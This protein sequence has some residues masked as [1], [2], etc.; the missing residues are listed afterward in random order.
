MHEH[1][2]HILIVDDEEIVR[3]VCARSLEGRGYGIDT[4]ENGSQ[5][6]KRLGRK[7]YEI[8]FTDL[9]MPIVNG[10]ELL[11][12]IKR[13]HPYTEVIV[14]TGFATV[15]GAI[16][17]MK[18]GAYD[19]ILKPIKPDQ[20]RLTVEKCLSRLRLSKENEALRLANQKLLELKEIKDKFIAITSHELRTPVSHIKGYLD[21]VL[22][23]ELNRQLSDKE[24]KQCREVILSAVKEM[25]RIVE[26]MHDLARLEEDVSKSAIHPIDINDLV[27]RVVAE[28]QEL[29]KKRQQHIE[30]TRRAVHLDVVA[31]GVKIEQA[32]GELISNAIK[33]TPDGGKVQ[34]ETRQD[35]EFCVISV[36]DSGVGIEPAEQ[37]KIFDGF[38]EVQDSRY[39]SSSREAFMGG[40]LGLGLPSARSIA[41]AH[42]GDIKVVSSKDRGA[43]FL[44]YLPLAK[45]HGPFN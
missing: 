32:V 11:D 33:F 1:E 45:E 36:K 6:L 42:G 18:K 20:I 24:Q 43:E 37:G 30:F 39:H 4:A 31:D 10:V 19:F 38:Y 25:E 3:E 21:I 22:N 16:D 34:V 40:G 8:V 27:E 2:A 35:G 5:A 28:Y 15:Q 17:A 41:H 13:D 14:M 9:K 44:V 7:T 12:S 29:V 26:R 23:D